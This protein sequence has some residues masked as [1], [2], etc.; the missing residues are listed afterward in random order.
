MHETALERTPSWVTTAARIIQALPA[1][2][3]RAMNLVGGRR[4]PPFWTSTPADLGGLEF[5]CDL[6]DPLMREVCFTGRYEPQE[7]LLVRRLLAPGMTFVDV[8]ANWGYFTLY[9]AH[10]VG[11]QGRVIGVEADP[12]A[13]HALRA[14]VERNALSQVSLFAAAA[15]DVPGTLS[16]F[17]YGHENDDLANFGVTIAATPGAVAR[18]PCFDVPARP[19][20]DLLDETGVGRIDLLKMDIEGG[21]AR[22]L[23][24]LE[25]RLSDDLID[26]I[27]LELH[28]AYLQHQGE[29]AERV[30]AHLMRYSSHVWHI[31]HTAAAYRLAATSLRVSTDSLLASTEGVASLGPW[32]HLLW[33]REGLSLPVL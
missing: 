22:A 4:S 1:G 21:E 25:R 7:T 12:R 23:K 29:T 11:T 10:L 33:Q 3:Y 31:D 2:R 28:P 30:I 6:R 8:G 18:G 19:L 16:M 15:S 24:G 26:R 14:N 20:D 5:R 9:A 13:W 17:T 27:L 32:P